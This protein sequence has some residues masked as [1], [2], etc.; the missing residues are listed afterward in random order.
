MSVETTKRERERRLMCEKIG[1]TGLTSIKDLRIERL[2]RVLYN[3]G[4]SLTFARTLKNHLT[5]RIMFLC[6]FSLSFFN[7]LITRFFLVA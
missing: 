4:S 6:F 1:G 5:L 2:R 7:Y 3:A